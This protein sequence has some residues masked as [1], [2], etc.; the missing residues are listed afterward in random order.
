MVLSRG[1]KPFVIIRSE[2]E[3]SK[4]LYRKLGFE[5][6]FESARIVYEPYGDENTIAPKMD[7]KIKT[8]NGSIKLGNGG[9]HMNGNH[10]HVKCM[11]E[12]KS[13]L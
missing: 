11:H 5:K 10:G 2:N 13:H 3:A 4:S 1:Y 8:G 7:D 12:E 6:K 9:T